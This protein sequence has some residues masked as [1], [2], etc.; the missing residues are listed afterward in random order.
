MYILIKN[1]LLV[2]GGLCLIFVLLLLYQVV[3]AV[4][5][6]STQQYNG[7]FCAD[8]TLGKI[9]KLGRNTR[10]VWSGESFS[11]VTRIFVPLVKSGNH[12]TLLVG[13]F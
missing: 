6:K 7:L 12:W 4:L 3:E 5:W 9:V 13:F 1:N 8:S 2:G 11:N 10:L